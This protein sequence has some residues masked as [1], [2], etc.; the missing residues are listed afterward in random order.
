VKVKDDTGVIFSGSG[1]YIGVNAD[2][3]SG[4]FLALFL[5]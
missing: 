4:W 1:R 3:I 2:V 5:T